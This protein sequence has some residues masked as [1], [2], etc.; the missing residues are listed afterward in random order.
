MIVFLKKDLATLHFDYYK[1]LNENMQWMG[2]KLSKHLKKTSTFNF[3]NKKNHRFSNYI[4][5]KPFSKIFF[6]HNTQVQTLQ[7]CYQ[8]FKYSNKLG[9]YRLTRAS[10]NFLFINS[11]SMIDYCSMEFH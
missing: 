8:M 6:K 7:T 3:S 4:F 2:K 10:Y 11:P 5:R 9:S 1:Q